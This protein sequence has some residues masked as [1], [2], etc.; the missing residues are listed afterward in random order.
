VSLLRAFV[1]PISRAFP[2]CSGH[3]CWRLTSDRCSLF[4]LAVIVTAT[5]RSDLKQ[6][7]E[8]PSKSACCSMYCVL[9]VDIVGHFFT[10][11]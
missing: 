5:R 9:W 10:L 7:V 4:A 1:C 11:R 6:R 2:G 3:R 8:R